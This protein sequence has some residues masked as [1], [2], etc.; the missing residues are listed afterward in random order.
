MNEKFTTIIFQKKRECLLPRA[1]II[2]SV[3]RKTRNTLHIDHRLNVRHSQTAFFLSFF[4][5][6][7]V[8]KNQEKITVLPLPWRTTQAAVTILQESNVFKGRSHTIMYCI[9]RNQSTACWTLVISPSQQW[10]PNV[11]YKNKE[12][13]KL[14]RLERSNAITFCYGISKRYETFWKTS[15]WR[16][17]NARN[18]SFL[19]RYGGQFTFST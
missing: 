6:S 1:S 18:V 7:A 4:L 14:Q 17:G 16:R 11:T 13:I 15:L 10:Y 3:F 12:I 8:K 2:F 5:A 19:T 9:L